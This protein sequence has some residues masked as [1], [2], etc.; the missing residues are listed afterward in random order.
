[1]I[2]GIDLSA[3]VSYTLKADTENPTVWKLGVLPSYL[4]G[5]MSMNIEKSEIEMAYK[6]LQISLKGWDNFN[7]EYKTVSENI[8][9][10]DMQVV[11]LAILEQIPLNAI[12]ELASKVL[13]INN[14]SSQERKN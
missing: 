9:G 3:T 12:S 11:P 13:E 2:S 10:R 5:K 6:L 14:L 1:M 8:Y 7:V 4:L